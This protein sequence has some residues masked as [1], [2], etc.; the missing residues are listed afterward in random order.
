MLEGV[1]CAAVL[2]APLLCRSFEKRNGIEVRRAIS[3]LSLSLFSGFSGLPEEGSRLRGAGGG[4]GVRGGSTGGR[5]GG[6]VV[7]GGWRKLHIPQSLSRGWLL[8][9]TGTVGGFGERGGVG[10]LKPDKRNTTPSQPTPPRT[11]NK[12]SRTWKIW[13]RAYPQ[14]SRRS[15][16]YELS[17]S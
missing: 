7:E 16:G 3:R 1:V 15:P 14:L 12:A 17:E 13:N 2:L 11:L 5:G 4:L 9:Q 6:G 8:V 10:S